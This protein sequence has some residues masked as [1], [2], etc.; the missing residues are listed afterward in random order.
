MA[1][2]TASSIDDAV[3]QVGLEGQ[4]VGRQ[5]QQGAV[6][7]RHAGDGPPLGPGADEVVE[8]LDVV[9]D[10]LGQVDGVGH[11]RERAARR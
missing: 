7:G 3:G 9:A 2:S 10:A 1:S 4:L 11:G 6:D 5:P 8:Q